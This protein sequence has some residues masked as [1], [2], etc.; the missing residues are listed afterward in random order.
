VGTEATLE[1]ALRGPDGC[2]ACADRLRDGIAGH[3][4]VLGVETGARADSVAVRI[5]AERCSATCLDQALLQL[6]QSLEDTYSHEVVGVEGLDCADC[7]RTI[8]RAV[9][10]VPGVSEVSV[11]FPSGSMRVE[12]LPAQVQPHRIHAQVRRL[13]YRIPDPADRG[14]GRHPLSRIQVTVVASVLTVLAAIIDVIGGRGAVALYVAAVLAAG[15]PIARTGVQALVA[16][17]RPEI[18]LL[19]TIAV[20]GAAAIGAWLEAALVVVLFSIGEILE[21]RATE[22]ARR[23]LASLVDLTPVTARVRV[24]RGEGPFAVFTEAEV[25]V[26]EL[27]VGDVVAVRPGERLPVDGVVLDG[28]GAVDQAAITGES[29]PVDVSPGA[30]VFAGTLN[31][32]GMLLIEAT[33]APGD[34]TLD[35]IAAL[36]S[37]AQARRSP[38][39]RWVDAFAR[40]YTPAVIGLAVAVAVLSPPLLGTGW[41]TAFYD[42]LALLIL[43]CPCALVLSTPVTIAS[44]LARASAAGVLIKGGA[45]LEAAAAVRVVALDKTGTITSGRPAVT[46]IHPASTIPEAQVLALAAAVEDCSEHPLA[47][48]ITDAARERGIAVQS[49]DAFQALTGMGACGIVDGVPVTVGDPR[50]VGMLPAELA[51]ATDRLRAGGQT[52]VAVAA[53]GRIAGVIAIADT[54]RPDAA[55]AVAALHAMDVRTVIL[56]GDN[57]VT[58]AAVAA[59]VGVG[60][61]H[62]GLLPAHKATYVESLTAPAMVGDGVNDA[63]ALAAASVGVAMGTAGSD[64][65][66]EVADVAVMGDELMKIPGLIGLARWARAVVRQ[67]IRVSLFT[68]AAAASLLAGGALPLWGAVIADVGASLIV[69]GNGLRLVRGRPVTGAARRTVVLM[70]AARP[71]PEP[72]TG[73]SHDHGD[74][75]GG[76][77]PG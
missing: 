76:C 52:V 24:R 38:S 72:G 63:P 46:S 10:R 27:A 71:A 66:V 68:K 3:R 7:A 19:M 34:T 50:L 60:T 62:A 51:A 56:T 20:I 44:A 21:G 54:V 23:E 64:T 58:A 12:Y 30:A 1:L 5:D 61:V 28:E 42:A 18:K 37:Q 53:G 59:R 39:E 67:N 74:A 25:P 49:A 29:V 65:A 11:G 15:V 22:R 35:R 77:T 6:R 2:G 75:C 40:R 8:E 43:A 36:V 32:Q 9:S 41:G 47:A 4:G 48:A 73:Q 17:R 70:P 55:D 33:R 13:G 45:H 14:S 16:T 69:V 57:P 26:S 31:R